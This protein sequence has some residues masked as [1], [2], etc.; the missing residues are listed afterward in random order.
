[1]GAGGSAI[2]GAHWSVPIAFLSLPVLGMVKALR[3][4]PNDHHPSDK[5]T[6]KG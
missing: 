2:G 1:M 5:D 4:S 3:S 6:A